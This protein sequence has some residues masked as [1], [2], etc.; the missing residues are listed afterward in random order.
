MFPLSIVRVTGHSMEPSFVAGDYVIVSAIAYR[1]HAGD[2]VVLRHP[3][4]KQ[5]LIKRILRIVK[6]RYDVRGDHEMHS[7][8]SRTFGLVGKEQ[9]IGKVLKRIVYKK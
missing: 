8:D 2:I 6:N 7:T 3:V 4:S 5:L 1:L 9:I